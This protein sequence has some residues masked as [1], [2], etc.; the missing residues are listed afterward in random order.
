MP[1]LVHRSYPFDFFLDIQCFCSNDFIIHLFCQHINN[2]GDSMI[3]CEHND[4][5]RSCSDCTNKDYS[6]I[7]H[8]YTL[9]HV[10]TDLYI[11]K[12]DRNEW[13]DVT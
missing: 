8:F 3:V 11:E 6:S 2:F 9:I 7:H 4:S 5:Y 12:A 13:M 1:S 10:P